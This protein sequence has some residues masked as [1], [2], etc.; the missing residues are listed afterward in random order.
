MGYLSERGKQDGDG[1]Y[2]CSSDVLEAQDLAT[3]IYCWDQY[4]RLCK[5]NGVERGRHLT[6]TVAE[7]FSG[8]WACI[9]SH[10]L[11]VF[12]IQRMLARLVNKDCP[13]IGH[14]PSVGQFPQELSE[15]CFRRMRHGIVCQLLGNTHKLELVRPVA[16]E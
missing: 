2:S 12:K 13:R 7:Y 4:K 1:H 11:L 16:L 5:E 6:P 14:C 3:Q 8:F 15:L 9:S 10:L